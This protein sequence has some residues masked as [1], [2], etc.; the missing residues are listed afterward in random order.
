MGPI[1][2][3]SHLAPF[4]P[5]HAVVKIDGTGASNGAVSAAPFGSAGI[6]PISWMYIAMMGS[7]GLK[8]ATEFAILNANYVAKKLNPHFPVLYVG[9]HGRVA[10][11]G[12]IDIRSLK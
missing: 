12:I 1:G 10:H 5:N 4:L 7:E 11:V 2:V 6:L 9:T 8:Q 3:K